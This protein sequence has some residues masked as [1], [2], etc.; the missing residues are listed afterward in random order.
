M[1]FEE[2][3]DGRRSTTEE[4]K[5]RWRRAKNAKVLRRDTTPTVYG[6][7]DISWHIRSQFVRKCLFANT[8][9]SETKIF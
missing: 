2:E 3:E 7:G 1:E 8:E 9:M 6:G 5:D 4:N